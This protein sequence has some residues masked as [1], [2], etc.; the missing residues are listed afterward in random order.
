MQSLSRTRPHSASA[1]AAAAH[2]VHSSCTASIAAEQCRLAARKGR[3][4]LQRCR[5]GAAGGPDGGAP[6]RLVHRSAASLQ[7]TPQRRRWALVA[8]MLHRVCFAVPAQICSQLPHLTLCSVLRCLFCDWLFG[9]LFVCL[10]VLCVLICD[11]P[12]QNTPSMAPPTPHASSSR[13]DGL[14]AACCAG[15][16]LRCACAGA[17]PPTPPSCCRTSAPHQCVCV[18]SSVLPKASK[19]CAIFDSSPRTIRNADRPGCM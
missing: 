8:R 17:L 16:R 11:W 1:T 2:A 9:C 7:G 3:G 19:Y 15:V 6:G 4:Q 13:G 18:E 10:F 14:F 5:E 12:L